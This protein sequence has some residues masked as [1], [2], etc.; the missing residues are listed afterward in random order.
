MRGTI[1]SI[2]VAVIAVSALVAIPIA[3]AAAE[4]TKLLPEPTV[5]N[6]IT[7]EGNG[8]TPVSLR[9]TGGLEIKC[10]KGSG[11][12][13]WTSANLATAGHVLLTECTSALSSTCTGEGEP[14]GLIAALGEVHFWLALRMGGK[15]GSET[16]ELVSALV[17]LEKQVK[18]TC[19]NAAKTFKAETVVKEGCSAG[20]DSPASLN[21]LVSRVTETFEEWAP[22]ETK[23]EQV[24][25]LVLPAGAASE[26]NC[27]TKLAVNGGVELLAAAV[28]GAAFE[29]YKQN[30]GAL[31]IE[32]MH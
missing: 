5:S 24:I 8:S 19:T 22:T 4:E 14:A 17:F 10:Q 32:L 26:I 3:T 2:C 6:P 12:E 21:K 16:T 18:L 30:S 7:D 28:G 1:T 9:D 11:A 15:I 23:G 25:L 29:N 13:T 20:Q 27:L 31:T